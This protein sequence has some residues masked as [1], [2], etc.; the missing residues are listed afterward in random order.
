MSVVRMGLTAVECV[1]CYVAVVLAENGWVTVGCLLAFAMAML[2]YMEGRNGW[3]R[4]P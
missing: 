4:S 3:G 1:G 2:A